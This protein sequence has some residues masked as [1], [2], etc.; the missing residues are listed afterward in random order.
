MIDLHCGDCLE[1]MKQIPDNS[2][3]CII[4]SPPYNKGYWSSNRNINNGFYTKSRHI[5]YGTFDDK[6]NPADYDDWQTKVILECLR[7]LKPSG[8]LFY[9]HTDIL[10]NHNMIHPLFVY[11]FPIKQI[12]VWNRKNTPKLDKSYFFPITEYIF[13]IKK[14]SDARVFF[15]RKK[16]LF[17][18]NIWSISP[19]VKNDFPAPFPVELPENCILACTKEND[20]VL[21]CFMGSGTT[22]VAA[23]RLNR[24]FIGIEL[25]KK[26]YEIAKNR[27]E[28][29]LL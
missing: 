5:D 16:A 20:V 15:D 29:E 12:I 24:N 3:D 25:D 9:N 11:K 23:K 2:V 19:D 14:T 28:S 22:G 10:K 26:Y 13:W 7:I 21:D 8:S 17:N 27:I 18:S 1:V 6:M 4:T